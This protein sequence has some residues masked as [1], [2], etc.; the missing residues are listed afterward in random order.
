MAKSQRPTG[1][2]SSRKPA[3]SQLARKS[4]VRAILRCLG[5]GLRVSAAR[6]IALWIWVVDATIW[7][8]LWIWKNRWR[9]TKTSINIFFRIATLLSI[10]YLVF[11]R[12][13]E[14]SV[15]I[16]SPS[17]D[18]SDPLRIPFVVTNNSHVF[19]IRNIYWVCGS[20]YIINAS[21]GS[22]TENRVIRDTETELSPGGILNIGCNIAGPS[23][24]LFRMPMKF[25]PITKAKIFIQLEYDAD[26]FGF[27]WHRTPPKIDFTWFPGTA[28]SQWIKGNFSQ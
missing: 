23:S 28:S 19:P 5:R 22:F 16:S 25:G 13:Y 27:L 15:T 7:C 6:V 1:A 17:S 20:Y 21:G 4:L 12:I 18:P 10:G 14:T 26:I 2:S 8:P 9:S 24:H 11:D 3:P